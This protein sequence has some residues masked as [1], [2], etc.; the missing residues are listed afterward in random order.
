MWSR[1]DIK[2]LL[3]LI[4]VG[5]LA[6]SIRALLA[7]KES[8]AQK[9]RTFF[10]GVLMAGLCAFILSTTPL[11]PFFRYLI[12][13]SMSAFVSTVWPILEKATAKWVKTKGNDVSGLDDN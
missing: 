9:V 4:I 12:C 5:T 2:D 10:A 6:A 8:P 3:S 7:T 13:G 1:Q 11:S